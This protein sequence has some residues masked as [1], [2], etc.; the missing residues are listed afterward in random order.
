L[1]GTGWYVTDYK[2]N[3]KKAQAEKPSEKKEITTDTKT[4]K[5]S[6]T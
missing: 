4:E 6:A 5:A 3:G 2:N 1:K